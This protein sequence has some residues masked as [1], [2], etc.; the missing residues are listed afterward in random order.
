MLE[1]YIQAKKLGEAA[2]KAA[3]KNGESPYLPV[4]DEAEGYK[5]AL[6]EA[7]VGLMELPLSFITGNK[8]AARNNAFANN[9]MPLFLTSIEQQS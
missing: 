1:D 8:E 7:H 6:G 3:I 2:V 4:L 5:D 9:F